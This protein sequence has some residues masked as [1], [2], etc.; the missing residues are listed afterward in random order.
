MVFARSRT[1]IDAFSSNSA[2]RMG[3]G[4]T[5]FSLSEQA[6]TMMRDDAPF[7]HKFAPS[8]KPDD[9][10]LPSGRSLGRLTKK[11]C[12]TRLAAIL[13]SSDD[14]VL[15]FSINLTERQFCCQRKQLCFSSE[16]KSIKLLSELLFAASRCFV[17]HKSHQFH[18]KYMLF[19]SVA[20]CSR[21][22]VG[23]D[24]K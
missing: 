11:V 12:Q 6:G 22:A 23:D 4:L 2:C 7:P 13:Q 24:L 18:S 21:K 20:P 14:D 17:Q 5:T 19:C 10:E 3:K 15:T 16:V 8:K 1:G 9:P